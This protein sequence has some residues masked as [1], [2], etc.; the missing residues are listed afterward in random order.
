METLKKKY[1]QDLG[2]FEY[3]FGDLNIK[4]FQCFVKLFA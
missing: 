2:N 1:N 3:T 4:Q